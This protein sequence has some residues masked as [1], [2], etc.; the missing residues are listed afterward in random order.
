MAR[1]GAAA[2]SRQLCFDPGRFAADELDVAAF[3]AEIRS[4]APL[5]I[6]REDL[7]AHI[8]VLSEELIHCI[9]ADF[10]QFVALGSAVAETDAQVEALRSP[11]V[12]LRGELEEL[13]G[14]LGRDVGRLDASLAARRKLADRKSSLQLLLRVSELVG[15]AEKLL[16]EVDQ[17]GVSQG[18]RWATLER[19]C[20][21]WSQL[22]SA[23]RYAPENS[24]FVNTLAPR[25]DAVVQSL[26]AH[27]EMCMKRALSDTGQVEPSLR[28]VLNA[29]VVSGLKEQAREVFRVCVVAPFTSTNLRMVTAMAAAEKKR[30]FDGAVA[31][32]AEALD[33]AV[34]GICVFL[35]ERCAPIL[36]LCAEDELLRQLDLLTSVIWPSIE[37]AIVAEMG[38]V[39]SPGIASVFHQAFVAAN[40]LFEHVEKHCDDEGSRN[41]LRNHISTRDFW[42]RWNLPVYYQLRFQEITSS[43]GA[44][45]D[46]PPEL[47]SQ[48]SEPGNGSEKLYQLLS[49]DVYLLTATRS[50][51]VAI[52]RCW[53]T[54]VFLSPLAHR[55]LRLTLQVIA[56]YE[57]WVREGIGGGWTDKKVHLTG[58]VGSCSDLELVRSRL[59]AEIASLMRIRSPT[60]SSDVLSSIDSAIADSMKGV[61]ELFGPLSDAMVDNLSGSCIEAL[62][63]LRGIMAIYRGMKKPAPSTHSRYVPNILRSLRSFSSD[64]SH[65][66][67]EATKNSIVQ[68]VIENATEKYCT[69]AT[70]LLS[71]ARK[72]EETLK[73]LNIGRGAATTSS[74]SDK[75]CMQLFLDATKF[76]TEIE[77]F[78]LTTDSIPSYAELHK[79]VSETPEDAS[80]PSTTE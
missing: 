4:H 74:D 31:T 14:W 42:K 78:G 12:K 75:I 56:R 5:A 71:S 27:L 48:S 69:M 7:R 58:A 1:S 35:D 21:E 40:R 51:I 6:I 36:R 64:K 37:G 77:S 16:E 63:P 62:Q 66:I 38:L 39:F 22:S 25:L 76:A 80:Q 32:P 2:G 45:L 20:S 17:P 60:L 24:K 59:P 11:L 44:T 55:L 65:Q 34:D 9:Q 70:D 29:F 13:R 26:V 57:T 41:A 18:E 10:S 30:D 33:A 46:G 28:A 19:A 47:A 54:D 67:S 73:R 49:S 23:L 3:V 68:R 50:M 53:D 8:K 43:Y 79:V 15:K 61:G 72:A 52:R